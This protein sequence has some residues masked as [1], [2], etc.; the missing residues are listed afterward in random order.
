MASNADLRCEANIFEVKRYY[1]VSKFGTVGRNARSGKEE[2]FGQR[3]KKTDQQLL[4]LRRK[5]KGPVWD[6]EITNNKDQ[7]HFIRESVSEWRYF[8]Q[9]AK[10]DPKGQKT[11]E[12]DQRTQPKVLKQGESHKNGSI[13]F[14]GNII[15]ESYWAS[16]AD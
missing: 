13:P 6:M 12:A 1:F 16:D 5:V 8:D 15:C 11:L 4:E 3:K 7:L 14:Y 2:N 10:E 9:Q